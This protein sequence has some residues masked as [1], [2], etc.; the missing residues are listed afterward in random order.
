[1][2]TLGSIIAATLL[3]C[4]AAARSADAPGSTPDNLISGGLFSAITLSS[5]YRYEG[6]SESR[7]HPVV[8]AYLHWWRPDGFYLGVFATKVDFGY[9]GAPTYEI[10]TY[11][12]RNFAFDA[13]RTEFKLDGMYTAFPD[14]R[15][16][17]PTLNFFQGKVQLKHTHG[18]WT[19][20]GLVSYVPSSSYGSGPALRE[21]GEVDFAAA[22]ALTLT[23]LLGH[24]GEGIGHER[25]Y[26]SLG[27][28]VPWKTLTFALRYE[29]TDRTR[30]NCGF[31]PKACDAAVVGSMTVSLPPIMAGRRG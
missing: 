25:T 13:G 6:V 31:Q 1:M 17:G 26:W 30:L 10:D 29:D 11:G 18:P 23:A 7:G 9:P 16:P 2:K 20:I 22:T 28:Q 27:A 8:Q 21:E 24:Q 15:T 5:D 3:I 14:N 4:P 19:V 12:G